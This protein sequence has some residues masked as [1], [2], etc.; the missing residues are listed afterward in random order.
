MYFCCNQTDCCANTCSWWVY[1]NT[2]HGLSYIKV[3]IS[4]ITG[5]NALLILSN[6]YFKV[7][8][9]Q[10]TNS[11]AAP[12]VVVFWIFSL[13][14]KI[15]FLCFSHIYANKPN[16]QLFGLILGEDASSLLPPLINLSI[17]Q[18]GNFVGIYLFVMLSLSRRKCPN[19]GIY[20]LK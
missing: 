20:K 4:R 9:T 13:K 17:P 16:F 12:Q 15:K 18:L 6:Q 5:A 1:K 7:S 8:L 10:S 14:A 3:W 2:E 19:T 11:P